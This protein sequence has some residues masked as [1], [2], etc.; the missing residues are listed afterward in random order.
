MWN[1]LTV[2]KENFKSLKYLTSLW[3]KILPGNTDRAQMEGRIFDPPIIARFIKI[4]VK[5]YQERPSLRV[6]LYGC[7]DGMDILLVSLYY[8]FPC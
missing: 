8:I 7:S 1:T 5:T 3:L 2:A 6:E 4:N